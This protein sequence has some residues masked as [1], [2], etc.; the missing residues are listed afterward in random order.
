[1]LDSSSN[2][3]ACLS[4]VV[5][6]NVKNFELFLSFKFVMVIPQKCPWGHAQNKLPSDT[7]AF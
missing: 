7:L 5:K 2:Y 1:M 3:K 6:Y 4:N